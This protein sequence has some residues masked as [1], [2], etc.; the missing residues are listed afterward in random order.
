MDRPR[1][2][3]DRPRDGASGD[4][5]DHSFDDY[6]PFG[7]SPSPVDRPRGPEDSP[8]W[9]QQGGAPGYGY[10]SENAGYGHIEQGY[11]ANADS[12]SS[13]G[14]IGVGVQM[15]GG[16]VP[17]VQPVVNGV[18]KVSIPDAFSAA[19]RSLNRS[20]GA[21]L[22]F[23]AIFVGIL[24]AAIAVYFSVIASS[25]ALNLDSY[26]DP[27][28]VP[29]DEAVAAIAGGM[30]FFML[31]SVVVAFLW[32]VFALRGSF[33]AID[34]RTSTFR[35]FFKV[36]RWGSLIGVYLLSFLLQ[37]V[38]LLP[39]LA[40]IIGGFALS[41]SESGMAVLLLVLGYILLVVL[42]IAI[43][44]IV[45]VMPLLVM[46]GKSNALESPVIAWRVVKPQ[47]WIMV[48]AYIVV[49][50]VS[51]A[52]SLLF[53][54]GMLYTAPLAIILQVHVYRQLVG[55]RRVLPTV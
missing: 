42:G 11:S 10:Q 29:G 48:G 52:G 44:P 12:W 28:S 46:D 14:A 1:D 38:L 16:D 43:A 41:E 15:P 54:V 47:Y 35:T 22:G 55:G 21:W 18:T 6:N 25:G 39:G 4:N 33:E 51:A 2:P 40:L 9:N 3:F 19:F 32:E 53:Y 31:F 13:A 37:A 36:S 27:S 49:G 45:S 30:G 7:E 34:G 20:F 24:L 8:R 5:D 50:L 26:S 17:P 23:M